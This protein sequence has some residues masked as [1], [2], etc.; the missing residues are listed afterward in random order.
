MPK[1][2]IQSTVDQLADID[3]KRLLK[4]VVIVMLQQV[5][6]LRQAANLPAITAAEARS[7]IVAVYKK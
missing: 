5:N 4:A 6:T 1:I 2:E 7:A 3:P